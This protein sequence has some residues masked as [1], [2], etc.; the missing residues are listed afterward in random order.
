MWILLLITECDIFLHITKNGIRNLVQQIAAEGL[1]LSAAMD[2]ANRIGTFATSSVGGGVLSETIDGGDPTTMSADGKNDYD[3][4][5]ELF[6]RKDSS[7]ASTI[8]QVPSQGECQDD[9]IVSKGECQEDEATYTSL[10]S[11]S[12]SFTAAKVYITQEMQSI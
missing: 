7:A 2:Q 3:L 10:S 8:I 6:P 4:K 1:Q 9:I 12:T 5:M 11:S